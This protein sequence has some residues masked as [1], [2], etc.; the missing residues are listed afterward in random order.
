MYVDD[1][2]YITLNEE[3]EFPVIIN[4]FENKYY[5]EY[6]NT[7]VSIKKDDVSKTEVKPYLEAKLDLHN[8]A[9][10]TVKN[11]VRIK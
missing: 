5:V 2:K 11:N 7:L 3:M 1:S 10:I 9:E 4:N 8:I 6:N